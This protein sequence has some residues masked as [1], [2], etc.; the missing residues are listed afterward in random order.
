M[1]YIFVL[2]VVFW[3]CNLLRGILWEGLWKILWRLNLGILKLLLVFV[4]WG[5]YLVDLIVFLWGFLLGLLFF[6]S[7][8]GVLLFFWGLLNEIELFF[9]GE[10]FCGLLRKI[11]IK[12]I[13]FS[14][15]LVTK[16]FV[17]IPS[18]FLTISWTI[19]GLFAILTGF[20]CRFIANFTLSVN[21]FIFGRID[22]THLIYNLFI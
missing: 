14:I 19:I 1:L 13:F 17:H 9:V 5:I 20:S 11:I 15:N 2:K 3:G 8:L 7:S 21:F 4:L 12:F 18:F 22:N 10:W 6:W 16:H